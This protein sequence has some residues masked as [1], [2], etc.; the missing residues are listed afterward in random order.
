MQASDVEM[1]LLEHPRFNHMEGRLEHRLHDKFGHSS[2]NS[3]RAS[4]SARL[5]SDFFRNPR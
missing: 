1:I 2:F 3:R 5:A 4:S